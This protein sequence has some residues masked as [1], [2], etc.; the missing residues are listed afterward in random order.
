MRRFALLLLGVTAAGCLGG[1]G[2]APPEKTRYLL[3]PQRVESPG[4]TLAGTLRVGRVRVTSVFERKGF[5]YRTGASTYESDFYHEFYSPPGEMIRELT[6]RWF[7][8]SR[9]FDS[10]VDAADPAPSDWILEGV[11]EELYADQRERGAPRAIVRVE[12]TLIDGTSIELDA[13]HHKRYTASVDASRARPSQIV[14]AWNTALA[15]VFA[16]L[17][18]DVIAVLSAQT[19]ANSSE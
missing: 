18:A 5:V 8:G 12:F 17:E 1:F 11:V 19:Q 7:T 4:A 3:E 16:E 14:E 10:V 13:R 6:Q 2:Q 15:R 9:L